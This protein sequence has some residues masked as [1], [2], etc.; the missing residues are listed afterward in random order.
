MSVLHQLQSSPIC[1]WLLPYLVVVKT[2]VLVAKQFYN[3]LLLTAHLLL[4][5]ILVGGFLCLL[6]Q[7]SGVQQ[8]NLARAGTGL[9]L[10]LLTWVGV[11][12]VQ[13]LWQRRWVGAGAVALLV[14]AD[15]VALC[16]GMLLMVTIGALPGPN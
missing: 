4:A 10:L 3:I 2:K 15:G 6:L 9:A 16:G 5:G 13:R 12:L 7:R 1:K 14:G 11:L 8:F